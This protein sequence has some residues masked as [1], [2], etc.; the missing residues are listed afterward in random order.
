MDVRRQNM[1]YVMII[2]ILAVLILLGALCT[3]LLGGDLDS[4]S[5]TGS[6]PSPVT[7][8]MEAST[9]S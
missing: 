8:N 5:G 7:I 6:E 3:G 4:S 2:A 9:T 1:R